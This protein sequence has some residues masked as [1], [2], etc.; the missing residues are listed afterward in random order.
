KTGVSPRGF[1]F[2][3]FS[4]LFEELL[5]SSIRFISYMWHNVGQ[6]NALLCLQL[7]ELALCVLNYLFKFKYMVGAI[8]KKA[9]YKKIHLH[10][11]RHTHATI[12]N[13]LNTWV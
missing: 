11:M 13:Q 8:R 7:D 12:S 9:R 5:L 10:D 6:W 1:T 2:F 4:M 3:I